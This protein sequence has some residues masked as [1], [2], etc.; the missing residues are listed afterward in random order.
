MKRR[1][2]IT[3][4]QTKRGHYPT[5]WPFALTVITSGF[6]PSDTPTHVL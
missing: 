4:G 1:P 5:P 2:V 3:V 6:M